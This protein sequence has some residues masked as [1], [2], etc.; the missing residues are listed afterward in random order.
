MKDVS[1]GAFL[2]ERV[3]LLYEPERTLWKT[4]ILHFPA[5]ASEA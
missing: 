4:E 3:V 2:F 5:E 1:S